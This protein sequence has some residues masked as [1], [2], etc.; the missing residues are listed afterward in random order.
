MDHKCLVWYFGLEILKWT[1]NPN[2]SLIFNSHYLDIQHQNQHFADIFIFI[3]EGLLHCILKD[4][5]KPQ[6]NIKG[7]AVVVVD[8]RDTEPNTIFEFIHNLFKVIQIVLFFLLNNFRVDSQMKLGRTQ[9][10]QTETKYQW[11]KFQRLAAS[12]TRTF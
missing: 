5:Q 11:K 7:S 12:S 4:T 10:I 1:T 9:I 2:K 6:L 8:I 3:I